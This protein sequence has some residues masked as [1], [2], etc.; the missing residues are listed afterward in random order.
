MRTVLVKGSDELRRIF[1]EGGR[2][3]ASNNT[4]GASAYAPL[5]STEALVLDVEGF[6]NYGG[7]IADMKP[8]F[9]HG[10][11]VSR[12]PGCVSCGPFG[13]SVQAIAR[14]VGRVCPAHFLQGRRER[15]LRLGRHAC[16]TWGACAS[17]RA[18]VIPG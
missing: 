14:G 6:L 18:A 10:S 11:L 1:T 5:T 3:I 17:W 15:G 8:I 13:C 9:G 7:C 4:G 2:T 16:P 12:A